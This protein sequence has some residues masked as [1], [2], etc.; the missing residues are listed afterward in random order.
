MTF[1]I[2]ATDGVDVGVA[3]ASKF[4]A[5][6]AFVPH[7]EAGVGAAATQ[8]YANPRLGRAILALMRQGLSAKEA[9]EK[10]IA[11]DSE[12]EMRQVAAVDI[13][14]GAHAHTGRGCPHYA[15]HVVGS[16]YVASGN[17]LAGAE[18]LEAM[19]KGFET[20]RGELID[21][22]LAALEA[23]DRAGG[24]KRGRQSA[25]VV[26][27]RS[28][29]GYLG[30]TDVYVDIRV[31]DHPDPVA[32]LKRLFKIWE[33]TLL[34]RE[35]PSDVVLKSEVAAEVQATLKK[36]GF[37]PAEPTGVWDDETERA[38]REWAG[39]ENFENKVRNDD[40]IWSSLY[41]Y[42]LAKVQ[43]K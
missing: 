4:I 24:D 32:E 28:G 42:L 31:D 21:K 17:I 11:G 26:V 1:S 13:R 2:V 23:G 27:L 6:G 22:L 16:G 3:V 9:L 7:A 38:F 41:R 14:G 18:V 33:L 8:C 12:R 40:K 29:G 37:Y 30:L 5:V 10:A 20:Q 35:D 34:N 43:G 19:A 39:Y 36:L 25:A 15:G